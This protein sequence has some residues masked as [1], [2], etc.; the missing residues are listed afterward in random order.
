MSLRNFAFVLLVVLGLPAISLA[1]PIQFQYSVSD[2]TVLNGAGTDPATAIVLQQAQVPGSTFSFDPAAPA[3]VNL[4]AVNYVPSNLSTP[5]PIDIHP[6]GTTHWNFEGYFNVRVTVTDV[7][8]GE[9][10]AV[11]LGGRAHIY[12]HYS[13]TNGWTGDA[14]LWFRDAYQFNL[15]G[16]DY[17]IWGAND[18]SAAPASVNVWIG[19]DPPAHLTPEPGTFALVALGIVPLG[20]R[21]LRRMW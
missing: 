4:P 5:N 18:Y 2:F 11:T 14:I 12:N 7:A 15:G 1:G 13:T 3:P 8:S 20:L 17:T 16:N 21:R 9:S 10:Q 6:D 19:A